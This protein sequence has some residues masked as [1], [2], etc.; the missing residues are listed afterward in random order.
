MITAT[1]TDNSGRKLDLSLF[2]TITGPGLNPMQAPGAVPKVTSGRLKSAQ[3]YL[4]LLLTPL[5]TWRSDPTAGSNFAT[6]FLTGAPFTFDQI[7]SFFAAESLSVIQFM[8]V[9]RAANTP[10]DEKIVAADLLS[11]NALPGTLSVRVQLTYAD[12]AGTEIILP[13]RTGGMLG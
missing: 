10:D 2:P 6:R 7:P 11:Y 12:G 5:G 4:R 13:V 9:N 3:N 1:T 8:A